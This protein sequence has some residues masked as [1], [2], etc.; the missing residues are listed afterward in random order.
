M[1][2]DRVPCDGGCGATVR[3]DTDW[4]Y[5]FEMKVYTCDDCATTRFDA[6]YDQISFDWW[7]PL[8]KLE[9]ESKKR[10]IIRRL[11]S[12]SPSAMVDVRRLVTTG[13]RRG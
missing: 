3:K 8:L 6:L 7:S 4:L 2:S 1:R 5:L 12:M 10:D 11:G 9:A 13:G